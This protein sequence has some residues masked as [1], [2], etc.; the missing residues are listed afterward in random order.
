MRHTRQHNACFGLEERR[1]LGAGRLVLGQV[2]EVEVILGALRVVHFLFYFWIFCVL[3]V[4]LF[5]ECGEPVVCCSGAT[6][7]FL[8]LL[9]LLSN[10]D[11]EQKTRL[12]ILCFWDPLI[13]N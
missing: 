11:K 13:I 9:I 10:N 12:F 5:I 2:V 7:L 6:A 1:K 3:F 8:F 4:F